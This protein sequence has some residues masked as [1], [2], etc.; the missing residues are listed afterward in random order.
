MKKV[1]ILEGWL[2]INDGDTVL[3]ESKG[4]VGH[5]FYPEDE[6]TLIGQLKEFDEKKVRIIIE[7]IDQ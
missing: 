4:E 7:V 1:K 6:A 5:T 3:C 2:D